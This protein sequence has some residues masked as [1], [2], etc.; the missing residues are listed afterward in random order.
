MRKTPLRQRSG[1]VQNAPKRTP[2]ECGRR[3]RS[4]ATQR[5][6]RTE[7][8]KATR[9]IAWGARE[10][11]GGQWRG[12]EQWKGKMYE[13]MRREIADENAP[14][15]YEGHARVRVGRKDDPSTPKDG[16]M[17]RMS[18]QTRTYSSRIARGTK[19]VRHSQP[20][21]ERPK[22]R[23][24]P[25]QQRHARGDEEAREAPRMAAS[26][27]AKRTP[28]ENVGKD[29][30]N[31]TR[32]TAPEAD[33]DARGRRRKNAGREDKGKSRRPKTHRLPKG[34]ERKSKKKTPQKTVK[35]VGA[36]EEHGDRWKDAETQGGAKDKGRK[37]K[38]P[39]RCNEKYSPTAWDTLIPIDIKNRARIRR[40][41]DLR[42]S[43]GS[44]ARG[45]RAGRLVHGASARNT[46]RANA[47]R[48]PLARAGEE[49]RER[50]ARGRRR[51]LQRGS[52]LLGH[53]AKADIFVSV[54]RCEQK[55]L[56]CA[57]FFVAKVGVCA[58]RAYCGAEGQN[59]RLD[60]EEAEEYRL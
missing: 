3:Y 37:R 40:A 35:M 42:F 4:G 53:R 23:G 9:S 14:K 22:R 60:R 6:R 32:K 58:D 25:S 28:P 46:R 10:A 13:T 41:R 11:H 54:R 50:R 17:K 5:R 12:P 36:S 8:P 2:P 15:T 38:T 21:K 1:Q 16:L 18:A 49:L 29:A 55:T 31:R 47:P 57:V 51:R 48:K 56:D 43:R 39:Q 27:E 34:C 7:R 19:V 52:R 20:A 30:Q 59:V 26:S 44:D 45:A 24:L 33:V